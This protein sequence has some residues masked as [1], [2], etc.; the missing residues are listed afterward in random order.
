MQVNPAQLIQQI[1]QGQNPQQLML[2][3]LENQMKGTPIGDN[4]IYLAQNN[5]NA[6]IEQFARNLC[7][8]RGVDFDKEFLAFKKMLGL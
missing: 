2:F 6:D 1:K 7:A 4:L 3:V 5:R 8:Q